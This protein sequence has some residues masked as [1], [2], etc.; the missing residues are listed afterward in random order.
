MYVFTGIKDNCTEKFRVIQE[1][2]ESSERHDAD[3]F[4]I[5][6]VKPMRSLAYK[7]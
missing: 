1:E 6:S 7:L 3:F 4:L 5:F 2:L